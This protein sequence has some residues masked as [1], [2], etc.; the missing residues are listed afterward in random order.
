MNTTDAALGSEACRSGR[1]EPQWTRSRLNA[2][3]FT[4]GSLNG[5]GDWSTLDA[6]GIRAAIGMS[7]ANLDTTLSTLATQAS[8]LAVKTVTDRLAPMMEFAGGAW[9]WTITALAQAPSGGGGGVDWLAKTK[10]EMLAYGQG[11]GGYAA[12]MLLPVTPNVPTVVLPA[13]PSDTNYCRVVG[14]F[15]GLSHVIPAGSTVLFELT[16]PDDPPLKSSRILV[17]RSITAV[18]DPLGNLSDGEH[19][20][21][22]LERNDTLSTPNTLWRVTFADARM[23]RITFTLNATSFDISQLVN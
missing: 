4:S 17:G 7:L 9:R 5:K 13:P 6:A 23:T 10:A 16:H 21:I 2:P 15:G 20:W 8:V 12:A 3:S 11:T 1:M 22:D 19:A 14:Y 18:V